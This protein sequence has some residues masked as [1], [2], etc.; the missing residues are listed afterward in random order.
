MTRGF[1]S[2]QRAYEAAELPEGGCEDG[3]VRCEV[4]SGRGVDPRAVDVGQW[5]D[6]RCEVCCGD[7]VVVCG[8]G[9]CLLTEEVA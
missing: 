2:A 3:M 1:A 9:L 4:C 8:C 6:D 5:D 7:G